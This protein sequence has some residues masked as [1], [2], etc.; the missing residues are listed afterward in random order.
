MR[1]VVEIT[2]PWLALR[3]LAASRTGSKRLAREGVDGF[4]LREEPKVVENTV[5]SGS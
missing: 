2:V 1:R 4:P 3:S 5:R